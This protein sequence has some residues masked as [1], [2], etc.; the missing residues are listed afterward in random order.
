MKEIIIPIELHNKLTLDELLSLLEA[1]GFNIE[2]YGKTNYKIILS[3][4]IIT[5]KS[6]TEIVLDNFLNGNTQ[7]KQI[8]R[9][10]NKKQENKELAEYN[11]L[12]LD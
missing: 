1:N 8:Y 9:D 10:F 4:I 5:E 6:E 2:N 12:R 7:S 3:N 11:K